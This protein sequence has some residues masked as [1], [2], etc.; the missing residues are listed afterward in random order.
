[1]SSPDVEVTDIEEFHPSSDKDDA[2]ARLTLSRD[3]RASSP[4]LSDATGCKYTLVGRR[5]DSSVLRVVKR[6]MSEGDQGS[7]A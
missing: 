7:M 2:E 5:G 6:Q 1:M 4:D 3:N